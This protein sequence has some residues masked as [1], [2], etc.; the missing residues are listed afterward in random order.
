MILPLPLQS[1]L[2]AGDLSPSNHKVPL[3]I[4]EIGSG[5]SI[6]PKPDQSDW[7]PGWVLELWEKGHSFL[8][9]G[10]LA[11]GMQTWGCWDSSC[12]MKERDVWEW[13]QHRKSRA[14]RW[15]ETGVRHHCV[16]A[17]LWPCL[18]LPIL[19]LVFCEP[20]KPLPQ[21]SPLGLTFLHTPL[22]K[23][24]Q[25][26]GPES[27]LTSKCLTMTWYSSRYTAICYLNISSND[28]PLS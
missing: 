14:R 2:W 13:S 18:V 6:P 15:G 10:C 20:A 3:Q 27:C 25:K 8:L 26:Q 7:A 16:S 24:W 21:L 1:Q 9:W 12:P 23:S 28:M 19:A 4:S 17:W 5:S 11:N 22:K